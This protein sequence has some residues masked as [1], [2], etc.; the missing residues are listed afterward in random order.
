MYGRFVNTP[1]TTVRELLYWSYANLATAHMAVD[2]GAASYGS[3]HYSVRT[4][5]HKAFLTGRKCLAS[6]AADERLKMVLPQACCYCGSN[7]RLSIDHL[8]S[9]KRGGADVGGNTV[10]ACR[11]CNS[12]KNAADVLDWY[13]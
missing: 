8:I 4:Y 2:E 12:S 5:Y 6:I 13:E 9:K 1:T 7:D 10:W 3:K 11:P